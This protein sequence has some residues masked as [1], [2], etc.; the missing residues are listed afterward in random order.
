M[1]L[2]APS[3][4]PKTV[5]RIG[6]MPVNPSSDPSMTLPNVHIKTSLLMALMQTNNIN[7]PPAIIS[8]KYSIR[9]RSYTLTKLPQKLAKLPC[10]VALKKLGK[11]YGC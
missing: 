9:Q 1:L 3:P 4:K 5:R 11:Q 8:T 7:K 10:A 2:K 6:S